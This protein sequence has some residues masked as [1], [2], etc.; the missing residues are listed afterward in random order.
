MNFGGLKLRHQML[1][2]WAPKPDDVSGAFAP[3]AAG[4]LLGAGHRDAR[5]LKS[6]KPACGARGHLSLEPRIDH[7]SNAWNR[8]R[9][10]S[11]IRGEYDSR[12]LR[13]LEDSVLFR[14]FH[15]AEECQDLS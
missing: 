6:F 9:R 12:L 10:L 7:R 14:G 1:F 2:V 11:N 8:K 4:S 5:E 13:R 3:R 15:G